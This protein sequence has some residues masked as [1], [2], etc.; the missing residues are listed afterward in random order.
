MKAQVEGGGK[1]WP[2]HADTIAMRSMLV[3]TAR[4]DDRNRQPSAMD[5]VAFT[6]GLDGLSLSRS[7]SRDSD[8]YSDRIYVKT[9][10]AGDSP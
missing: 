8:N 5:Q 7:D 10:A 3:E 2:S 9:T 4:P 1:T 6:V